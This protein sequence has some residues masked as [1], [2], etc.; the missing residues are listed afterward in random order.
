MT[1][2]T[3]NARSA[4]SLARTVQAMRAIRGRRVPGKMEVRILALGGSQRLA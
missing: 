2:G 1:A 4:P 3:F